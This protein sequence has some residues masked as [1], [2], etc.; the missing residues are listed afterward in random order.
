MEPVTASQRLGDREGRRG[1]DGQSGNPRLTPH[2]VPHPKVFQ[3][4]ARASRGRAWR[5]ELSLFMPASYVSLLVGA[6]FPKSGRSG[7]QQLWRITP[8]PSGLRIRKLPR[9]LSTPLRRPT[10]TARQNNLRVMTH[11]KTLRKQI[12]WDTSISDHEI[13]PLSHGQSLILG[14]G[15][16]APGNCL[17]SPRSEGK[18]KMTFLP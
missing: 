6:I 10:F 4:H 7:S 5:P 14:G 15:K 2:F 13:P 9:L 3:H 8:F 18:K 1:R 11:D 12:G 16:E 17:L